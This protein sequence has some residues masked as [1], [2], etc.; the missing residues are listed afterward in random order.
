MVGMNSESEAQAGQRLALLDPV[1]RICE[2]AGIPIARSRFQLTGP[3]VGSSVVALVCAAD[4]GSWD[5]M[6][7]VVRAQSVPIG[8]Q[9]PS[10]PW[11]RDPRTGYDLTSDGQLV[12]ELQIHEDDDGAGGHGPRPLVVFQLLDG[13]EVAADTLIQWWR[14][15]A[16][17]HSPPRIPDPRARQRQATRIAERRRLVWAAPSVHFDD[18]PSLAAAHAAT[19]DPAALALHFPRETSGRFL[20]SALVALLPLD[21]APPHLRGPWLTVRAKQDQLHVAVEN[22]IGGNQPNRW[23]LTPWMWHRQHVGASPRERWQLDDPAQAQPYLDAL[24][25]GQ[26]TEALKLA[27]VAVDDQL[28][29]LLRGAPTRNFRAE[30]TETWV[31]NL[32]AG[33][34][35]SAPW[36]FT[37]AYAAWLTERG[38][39]SRPVAMFGLKGLGQARKPKVALDQTSS[40]PVLRLWFSGGNLILP[41]ALWT[42]PADL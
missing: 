15:P 28:A 36:R 9:T 24:A 34:S 25:A 41:S 6:L 16:L 35:Y 27:G 4:D 37:A 18:V 7:T 3:A 19:I 31:A 23:N 5:A 29:K 2:R 1:A 33:L 10:T 26:L 38:G 8:H 12:Y 39:R 17:Y 11:R 40:G 30:L 22:L 20:R 32:Y 14:R 21:R 42:I 13:A